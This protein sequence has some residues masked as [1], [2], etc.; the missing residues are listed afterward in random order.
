MNEDAATKSDAS[1]FSMVLLVTA[2]LFVAVVLGGWYV[3]GHRGIAPASAIV[4]IAWFALSR[5]KSPAFHAINRR[6]IT[7]VEL[8]TMITI[9]LILH[10]LTIPAVQSGP[11]PRRHAEP[12]AAATATQPSGTAT[13]S[14]DQPVES[15]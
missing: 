10:G 5:T 1:M 12:P 11:H 4:A 9:C 15:R 2:L 13:A 3:F 8:L 14:T 6:R 7:V